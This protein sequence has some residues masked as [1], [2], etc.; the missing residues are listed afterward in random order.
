MRTVVLF[1]LTLAGL[2]LVAAD[3]P[4]GILKRKGGGSNCGCGSAPAYGGYGSGYPTTSRGYGGY[5]YGSNAPA[6]YGANY[7][8]PGMYGGA[9]YDGTGYPGMFGMYTG[10]AAMPS[11]RGVISGATM[12]GPTTTYSGPYFNGT[13]YMVPGNDGRYYPST[14]GG[15]GMTGS[16]AGG[17]VQTTAG[18]MTTVRASM[19]QTTDGKSYV[20]GGDGAYY[21]AGSM[22]A[23]SGTMTNRTFYTPGVYPA[24]YTGPFTGGVSPAGGTPPLT[25]PAPGAGNSGT[26]VAP[27]PMPGNK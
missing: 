13:N 15:T 11:A 18:S 12:R 20:L 16:M 6:M 22:P 5:G 3:A 4:A 2:A 1:A 21:P 9:G 25:M 17:G 27:A 24:G 7:G 8:Y 14:A 10:S 19:I 23:M 26:Q